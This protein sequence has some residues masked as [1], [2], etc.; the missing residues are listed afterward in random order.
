MYTFYSYELILGKKT[1]VTEENEENL[2][3]SGEECGIM[4]KNDEDIDFDLCINADPVE[5]SKNTC[6]N[7]DRS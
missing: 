6:G 7:K 3:Q 2:L 4:T 1:I 5:R